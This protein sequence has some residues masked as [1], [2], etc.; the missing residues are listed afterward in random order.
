M[1]TSKNKRY[2]NPKPERREALSLL[3]KLDPSF[4]KTN[5]DDIT[6]IILKADVTLANCIVTWL[7]SSLGFRISWISY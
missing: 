7:Q 3:Q 5:L 2:P 1:K 6:E 4:F